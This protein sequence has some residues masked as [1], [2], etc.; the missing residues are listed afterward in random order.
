MQWL[1]FDVYCWWL[2]FSKV[3]HRLCGAGL[4]VNSSVTSSALNQA[5]GSSVTAI[6]SN[7]GGAMLLDFT[8]MTD[9]V[10]DNTAV[11]SGTSAVHCSC[12][13]VLF[14]TGQHDIG[15]VNKWLLTVPAEPTTRTSCTEQIW[16]SIICKSW[17]SMRNMVA[18]VQYAL[19]HLGLRKSTQFGT[20]WL[21]DSAHEC[22]AQSSAISSSKH[23]GLAAYWPATALC[24]PEMQYTQWSGLRYCLLGNA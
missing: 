2:L 16:D 3:T 11:L 18:V 7:S 1:L 12:L 24:Q 5:V 15:R 20:H 22:I 6:D 10:D 17:L 19:L 4:A 9:A 21:C 8:R 13:D 14:C 23:A